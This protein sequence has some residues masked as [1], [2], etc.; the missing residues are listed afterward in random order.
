MQFVTTGAIVIDYIMDWYA[1]WTC[2]ETDQC[3]VCDFF[4][5]F[6]FCLYVCFLRS[7][8]MED[9]WLD[10]SSV[11]KTVAPFSG[12]SFWKLSLLVLWLWLWIWTLAYAVKLD[13]VHLFSINISMVPLNCVQGLHG[14][15]WFCTTP[16]A[17]L[18]AK[19]F[20]LFICSFWG[21]FISF[22]THGEK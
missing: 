5:L 7:Y 2:Y 12:S 17:A 20:L 10:M 15:R 18:N 21:L 1:F 8:L 16:M 11:R 3:G 13:D 14:K 9:E 6:F 22:C 4:M 19:Y